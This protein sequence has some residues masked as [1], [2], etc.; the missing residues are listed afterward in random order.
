MATNPMDLTGATVLVT[1]AS[2]GIGRQTAILLSCLG[3]RV[4]L[5]GRS[6]ERLQQTLDSLSGEGHRMEPFDLTQAEEI[7]NW[8]RGITKETGPLNGLVHAAGIQATSPIRFV[9]EKAAVDL[10]RINLVSAIM[11]ARAFSH[12]ECHAARGRLVF[13][14][15][16]AGLN[17][18]PGESV[19]SA[20][21]AA[22]I[23]LAKSL[24]LELAPAGI[25][26]NCVAPGCVQTE[27]LDELRN[28]MPA[29]R[30]SALER[31]HPLGLGAPSDVANA[32][33]FLMAE[34][35]RWIT[36]TTLIVDGGYSAQ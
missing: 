32:V 23:G 35:G 21:K 27:M 33:A 11:L 5:C 13:L 4:V 9:T 30:F 6:R 7:P 29:E 22:L 12:R 14:S 18:S 24:A 15:S 28:L 3:A 20:S 19:Y 26:V 31:A 17:G 10:L 16:I 8:L 2:S 36:G 1:G 34:T 25:R